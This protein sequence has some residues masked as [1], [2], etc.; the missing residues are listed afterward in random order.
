MDAVIKIIK[1]PEVIR[2]NGKPVEQDPI[3]VRECWAE[4]NTLKKNELYNAIQMEM[5]TAM[6]FDIRYCKAMDEVFSGKG[7]EVIWNDRRF[8]IYDVDFLDKQKRTLRIRA[9]AVS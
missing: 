4:I 3:K 1:E 7:Y 9:E 5:N 8:K 2:V 6:T